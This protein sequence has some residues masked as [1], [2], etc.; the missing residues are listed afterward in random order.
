M[1]SSD[2]SSGIRYHAFVNRSDTD[3]IKGDTWIA[4]RYPSSGSASFTKKESYDSPSR[5]VHHRT[6]NAPRTL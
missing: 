3:F 6:F 5:C 4:I 2:W 1:D